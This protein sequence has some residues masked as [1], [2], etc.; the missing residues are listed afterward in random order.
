MA[1]ALAD[2]P[3]TWILEDNAVVQLLKD[4]TRE[5]CRRFIGADHLL[6]AD[7]LQ[8]MAKEA[9]TLSNQKWDQFK[10]MADK[11]DWESAYTKFVHAH[12][13]WARGRTILEVFESIND[14]TVPPLLPKHLLPKNAAGLEDLKA[15]C[16]KDLT[17]AFVQSLHEKREDAYKNYKNQE[18]GIWDAASTRDQYEYMR[19]ILQHCADLAKDWQDQ[20][21]Q[22]IVNYFQENVN[23]ADDK[24]K[25]SIEKEI[26]RDYFTQRKE[27]EQLNNYKARAFTTLRDKR[28]K[29]RSKIHVMGKDQV[30]PMDPTVRKATEA[31]HLLKDKITEQHKTLLPE[32]QAHRRAALEAKMEEPAELQQ[33]LFTRQLNAPYANGARKK[34]SGV[35]SHRGQSD[36]RRTANDQSRLGHPYP[37]RGQPLRSPK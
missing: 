16:T 24:A 20:N 2:S 3:E 10:K 1:C 11:G 9:E 33:E 36:P 30:D 27:D 21:P 35:L 8:K 23:P 28:A 18:R 25:T 29:L 12:M 26:D 31:C 7:L 22:L 34:L 17:P 13:N 37:S 4:A 5:T 14:P 19:W 32:L 15:N 6:K